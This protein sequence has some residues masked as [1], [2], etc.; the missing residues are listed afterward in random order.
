MAA[1]GEDG[2]AVL[3]AA[4]RH[5]LAGS[6]LGGGCIPAPRRS[7]ADLL[8]LGFRVVDRDTYLASDPAIVDPEREI[9]NTGIL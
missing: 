7:R 2:P 6:T 9:V 8:E 3:L 5:G 1:P 4:L